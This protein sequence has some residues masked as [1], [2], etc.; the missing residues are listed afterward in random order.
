MLCPQQ[1]QTCSTPHWWERRGR[2]IIMT[3][4]VAVTHH[5]TCTQ[6]CRLLTRSTCLA[7]DENALS[8]VC[9]KRPDRVLSHV[10]IERDCVCSKL[11][12]QGEGI[13]TRGGRRRR[14]CLWKDNEGFNLLHAKLAKKAKGEE[15]GRS[16]PVLADANALLPYV[17]PPQHHLHN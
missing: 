15:H 5:D 4:A 12:R 7:Q 3:R 17:L 1:Q 6:V 8:R 13:A 2:P 10:R 16:K 11:L 14:A 9:Q